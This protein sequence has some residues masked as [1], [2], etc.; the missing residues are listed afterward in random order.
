MLYVYGMANN[1]FVQILSEHQRRYR[2]NCIPYLFPFL[3]VVP[4]KLEVFEALWLKAV[5]Q[6][7]F[8]DVV[9]DAIAV[10]IVPIENA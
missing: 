9:I 5:F 10:P 7:E 6:S 2:G 4:T 3:R 8:V 1:P